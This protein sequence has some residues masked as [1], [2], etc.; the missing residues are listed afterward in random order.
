[1][2]SEDA[3]VGR[4]SRG[5]ADAIETLLAQHAPALAGFVRR[6]A[7]DLTAKESSSDLVQ[8]V[9]REVLEGL[10]AGKFD[11]RGE[12]AFRSW[13]Y[14]AALYKIQNRRRYW[15]A[16]RREG[17]REVAA[18][19][20][21]DSAQGQAELA[22]STRTPSRDAVDRE[23]RGELAELLDELPE[24]YRLVVELAH[25]EGCP[26]REIARRMDIGEEASRQ[27]LNRALARLATLRA[28]RAG[29][30]PD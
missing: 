12:E 3:L 8:S 19:R 24:R 18:P 17:A 25:L 27:L 14:D 26:H 1:M 6:K 16:Q 23:E 15:R 29:N 7:G 21:D 28:R 9:C 10:A 5:D 11:Y 4:A 30:G 20:S 2:E 22:R 13:L